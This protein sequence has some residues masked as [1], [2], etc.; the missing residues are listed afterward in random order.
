MLPELLFM[1][2]FFGYM[3]FCIIYKWFMYWPDPT[4]APSIINILIAVFM[5]A[6]FVDTVN[7]GLNKVS[8]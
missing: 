3:V 8:N 4:N 1:L 5:S 2:S 7:E 6:G